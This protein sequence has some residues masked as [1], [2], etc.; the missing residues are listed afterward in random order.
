MVADDLE[1]RILRLDGIEELREAA[2]IAAR[3]AVELVLVA[4]LDVFQRERR[5]VAVLGAARAPLGV[6]AAGHVLDLVERV[7]DE[8]LEVGA[9][10]DAL[11]AQGV[12][13]VD[14]QHGLHVQVLAPLQEF[15]QAHAVGRPVAPGVVH[16]AGALGDI[17]DGLL[18]VEARFD[19]VAFQVIAAGKAQEGRLHVGQQ[20]HDVVAIAVRPVVVGG[21]KERDHAEP[22]RAFGGGRKHQLILGGCGRLGIR[23]EHRLV[24]FPVS[25]ER[26]NARAGLHGGAFVADQFERDGSL[27]IRAGLGVERCPVAR[28]RADRNSPE[29]LVGDSGALFCAGLGDGELETGGDGVVQA[30]ARGRAT[31]RPRRRLPAPA[32]SAPGLWRLP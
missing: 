13:G 6:R 30:V 25:G 24:L 16:V 17:A 32:T 4:D 5:G 11:L 1:L 12:A 2:V 27:E 7:L 23:G 31:S 29:S 9:G 28:T 19:G 10:L 15:Q 20:L 21:R 3:L 8:G 14:G 22:D 18:P 26:G